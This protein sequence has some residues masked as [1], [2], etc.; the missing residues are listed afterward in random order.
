MVGSGFFLLRP[1]WR[2]VAW[3]DNFLSSDPG[4]FLG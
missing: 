3:L 2:L 4:D 1:L